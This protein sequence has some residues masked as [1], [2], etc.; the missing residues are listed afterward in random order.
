MNREL[1]KVRKWLDANRLSPKI[2]GT[3]FVVLHSPQ[4]KLVEPVIIRLGKKKIKC[5]S[6]VKFLG[7]MLD[8]NLSW[9]YH[10]A[11][12]SKRLSRSIRI[13]YKI[14]HFIPLEIL[15]ILYYSLFCS[16]VP[17]E[18]ELCGAL[19]TK[20]MFKNFSSSKENCKS[21]DFY[22]KN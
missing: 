3:D 9:K 20:P 17:L 21:C 13:F 18:S 22:F 4:I 16:P 2:D 14:Q 15:K 8:A 10:I 19:L 5:E 7:I 1:K 6:C 12:L 11:E